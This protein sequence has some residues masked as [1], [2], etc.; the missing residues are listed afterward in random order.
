MSQKKSKSIEVVDEDN[1][2]TI[3]VYPRFLKGE[4]P[5]KNTPSII[6]L[7]DDKVYIKLDLDLNINIKEEDENLGINLSSEKN[8][9]LDGEW[10][11]RKKFI[12][13]ISSKTDKFIDEEDDDAFEYEY[14]VTIT[15]FN[16]VWSIRTKG[17]EAQQEL[18][19]ILT[20]WF[21]NE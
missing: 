19:Q 17:I 2:K 5:T 13:T 14:I 10:Y 6:M 9:S 4:K 12:T 15:G 21:Y 18:L 11:T 3:Y 8:F 1:K 16:D 20:K 7:E